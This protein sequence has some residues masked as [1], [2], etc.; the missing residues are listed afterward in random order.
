VAGS[1]GLREQKKRQ[2]REAL[3]RAALR[4]FEERGF[5]A[6]TIR[7]IAH[8]AGMSP[9]TFF[10]YFGSKE[11]VIF[12]RRAHDFAVLKRLLAQEPNGQGL[13]GCMRRAVSNFAEYLQNQPPEVIKLRAKLLAAS[14]SLRRTLAYEVQAWGDE[15]ARDLAIRE[16]VPVEPRHHLI[17]GV[18]LQTLQVAGTAWG[19][20]GQA[21]F[22]EWLDQMFDE[23]EATVAEW[24]GSKAPS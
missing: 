19:G 16:G 10:R 11:D 18:A 14:S 13:C 6:T 22:T 24:K 1:E 12:A 3:E 21:S 23:L 20:G 15:L 4:L 9:R 17:A 7:E 2:A 8:A 5:D